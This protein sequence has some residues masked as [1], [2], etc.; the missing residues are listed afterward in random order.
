MYI[1]EDIKL[2][3]SVV[4]TLMVH[5]AGNN[6]HQSYR[7]VV[8]QVIAININKSLVRGGHLRWLKISGAINIAVVIMLVEWPWRRV[9]THDA[10]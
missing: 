10:F 8:L 3:L 6:C 7:K 5:D 4:I 1:G 9:T 2:V